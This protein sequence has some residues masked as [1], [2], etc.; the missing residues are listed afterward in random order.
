[1]K[2]RKLITVTL[3]VLLLTGMLSTAIAQDTT[4]IASVEPTAFVVEATPVPLE[5]SSA[6]QADAAPEATQ[7]APAATQ[8]VQATQS[9]ATEAITEAPATAV[10]ET[11]APAT[12]AQAPLTTP[13][14]AEPAASQQPKPTEQAT[15][16]PAAPVQR[17]VSIKMDMPGTLSLGDTVTLTATLTGYEGQKLSLQWQYT[18]DGQ[19]WFDVEG[20]NQTSYAF[21][22]S[23]QTAGTGWRLA[24]TV[25]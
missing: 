10:P 5:T 19:Q 11:Q 24:V 22:V 17:S 13:A 21:T 9:E 7:E 23:E 3:M 1:M 4:P 8:A 20:A 16:Q 15:E 18:F 25:L 12:T 14:A 2:S 6:P